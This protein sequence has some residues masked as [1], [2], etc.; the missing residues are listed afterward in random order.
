MYGQIHHRRDDALSHYNG[1]QRVPF[2]IFYHRESVPA[3]VVK[4]KPLVKFTEDSGLTG[5]STLT[6]YTRI[7][8]ITNNRRNRGVFLV[9]EVVPV[10]R[11][12]DIE[13]TP[14]APKNDDIDRKKTTAAH[15]LDEQGIL[16]STYNLDSGKKAELT[17]SY[18]IRH[19]KKL[20]VTPVE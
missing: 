15:H 19:P 18:S 16:T 10:S 20:A 8:E 12:E 2:F 17:F 14:L 5:Q 3:I 1:S 7:T 11:H 9:K 6:T 13:V 4:R